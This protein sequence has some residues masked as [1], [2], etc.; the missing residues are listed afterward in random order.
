[1][2]RITL[3]GSTTRPVSSKSPV[4][5]KSKPAAKP[6][7]KAK[8][9][10]KP[11]PKASTKPAPNP[12][13]QEKFKLDGLSLKQLLRA[14]PPYIKNNAQEVVIKK[15]DHAVSKGGFP[16]IK[17]KALSV[18][19]LGKRHIYNLTVVGK[20]KDKDLSKQKHVVVSCQCDFFKYYS[21]TAL[22][23]WGSAQIKYS[24]GEHPGLTNPGLQPLLCKHLVVLAR[25]IIEH[26]F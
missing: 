5:V 19:N 18:G 6:A 20:E 15:L 17:A 10:P 9:A 13:K 25:T 14:T 23:H 4:K 11:L 2:A 24:N 7:V 16:G 26:G 22:H 3:R 1:M 12:V 21:E 8:P